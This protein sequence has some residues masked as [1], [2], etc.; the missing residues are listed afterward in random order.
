M[1]MAP[2]DRNK[3]KAQYTA[4]LKLKPFLYK[5]P[6]SMQSNLGLGSPVRA[7]DAVYMLSSASEMLQLTP[8]MPWSRQSSQSFGRC[9]YVIST[10]S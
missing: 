6:W 8:M 3:Y 7:I 4:L 10:A 1:C 2:P 9:T 5:T